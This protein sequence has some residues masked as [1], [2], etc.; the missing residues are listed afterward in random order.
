[1]MRSANNHS[2]FNTSYRRILESSARLVVPEV[3]PVEE[4][5][6][7]LEL[8][9]ECAPGRGKVVYFTTFWKAAASIS[10]LVLTS[11]LVYSIQRVNIYVPKAEH[12]LV[13]LPDGSTVHLNADSRITYNQLLWKKNR[14][15]SF[16]GE[17]VFDV[18]KGERFSVKSP[19]GFVLVKG[20]RFNVF[21][22]AGEFKVACVSGK[23][24]VKGNKHK[25]P[26]ELTAGYGTKNGVEA[27]EANMDKEVSWQKG[28]FYFESAPVT[29]VI[30]TLELQYDVNIDVS[31]VDSNRIYTG[32]FNNSNLKEALQLVC[33]PL[34]WNYEILENKQIRIFKN[35]LKI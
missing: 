14:T 8:S 11:L 9:L 2:D 22:R 31:D 25:S 29:Y 18:A 27:E 1:M 33:L 12:R 34:E 23:V 35:E 24:E 28:E 15:V 30:S 21:D 26:V 3:Q 5:W 4:V 17:A 7:R 16:S 20:T 6:A 13:Y 32:Y 10:L 19:N